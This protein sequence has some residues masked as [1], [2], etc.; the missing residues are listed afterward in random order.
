MKYSFNFTVNVIWTI[1]F[2]FS[3]KFIMETSNFV[4]TTVRKI[5]IEY[6][7]TPLQFL[8]VSIYINVPF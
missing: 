6:M 8:A 2:F 1:V 4:A 5:M 7:G 3:G